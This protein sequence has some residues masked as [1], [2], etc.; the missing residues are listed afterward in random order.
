MTK[1]RYLY[2]LTDSTGMSYYVENGVVKR[3]G[4]LRPLEY[5]PD[6]WNKKVVNYVRNATYQGIF[7]SFSVP[8]RFVKD[9]AH[10]LRQ[11]LYTQGMEDVVFLIILQLDPVT[12][13]HKS[14]FKGEIDFSKKSNKRNYFQVNIIEAG[15]MKGLKAYE[16]V[17]YEKLLDGPDVVDVKMDGLKLKKTVNFQGYDSEIDEDFHTAPLVVINEE[18]TSFGVLSGDS[19]VQGTSGYSPSTNDDRWIFKCVGESVTIKFEGNYD[20]RIGFRLGGISQNMRVFFVVSSGAEYTIFNSPVAE[21][22]DYTVDLNLSIP[23]V[24]GERLFI[25]GERTG[26]TNV[27]MLY[28][29]STQIKASFYTRYKTT[30]IKAIKASALGKSLIQS[31]CGSDYNFTSTS[32][33]NSKIYLTCGDAIRGLAGAKIKTTWKDFYASFS[34]NLMLGLSQS[35]N[36]AEMK[37]RLDLYQSSIIA[38]LGEVDDCEFVFAEDL[39]ANKIKIG[40][41]AQDYDDV[42]GRD[43]FNNTHEYKAPITRINKELDLTAP[44]RADMYGIEFL[45]I[46]L[47]GKTTTDNSSD[48]TVFMIMVEPDTDANDGTYRLYRKAYTS[49]SGL[50]D[51][52]SAFNIELSV[53]RCLL[54]WGSWIRS[55]MWPMDGDLLKFQT[56]E[57]N[58]NLST[59]EGT[60]VIKESADVQIGNLSAPFM[61]PI[62]AKFK[63][64]LKVNLLTLM[65]GNSYGR[66]QFTYRGKIYKGW[67]DECSQRPADKESQEWSLLLSSDNDLNNLIYG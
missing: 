1:K 29:E 40:Y 30:Y 28:K 27:K 35:G 13:K 3:S 44:Y 63:P 18:G 58:P 50:I 36:T 33:D 7:R 5:N 48:N 66:Y 26:S 39:L 34:R 22:T 45:R 2:F 55:I 43:E 42:N 14:Y 41:P 24:D 15:L 21:S 67:A 62:R 25:H 9:G 46:N 57:K 53:K 60:T 10:I 17:T 20:F 31:M 16:G 54:I 51:A 64:N 12:G 47:D 37:S 38:D 8:L 23:L 56:T 11:R 19:P 61:I 4:A 6:G 65:D 52:V 59:T 49:V 32:L